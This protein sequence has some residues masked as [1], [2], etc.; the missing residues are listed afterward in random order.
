MN[1]NKMFSLENKTAVVIGGAGKIGFP[2]S[3]ALAEAGACVFICST[4]FDNIDKAVKKL[5]NKGLNVHEFVLDQTNESDIKSLINKINCEFPPLK[6]LFNS[7]VVRP[8][9]NFFE[10]TLE[11]FNQSMKINAGGLF[12][13]CKLFGSEIAKNGGGSIVNISSI[14]GSVAP[15]MK[16]YEGSDFETEP[17]YPYTKGGMNMFSKYWASYFSNKKVRV[18]VISPGGFFNNQQEPFLSKY[19]SKVPMGRM[20]INKDLKGVSVFLASDASDYI[21]GNNIFVDGGFNI[22]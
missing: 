12:L 4:N 22:I 20:A 1:V 18:N 16:I 9:K 21:T 11:N 3:E 10:D 6:I 8:M 19:I 15:D 7:G 5:K 2:I 14:Y 17:D 13:T